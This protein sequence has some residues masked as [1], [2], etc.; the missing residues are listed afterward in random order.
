M[1]L[2]FWQ[3]TPGTDWPHNPFFKGDA[4]VWL[5]YALALERGRPFEL[6]LPL[7]PPGAA[8]LM[9]LLWD[10][11]RETI[12]WLRA[13]WALQGALVPPLL[14]VAVRQAF[15]PLVAWLASASAVA[16]TGL[17]LLSSALGNE[18][19][20][21]VLVLVTLALFE[22]LRARPSGVRLGLWSLVHGTACLFRVEHA[23]FYALCLGLLL[24]S[25]ARAPRGGRGGS[26]VSAG[27]AALALSAASFAVP[28]LPWHL[29]AWRAVRLFNTVPPPPEGEA[30]FQRLEEGLGEVT[31]DAGASA[32][33]QQVPA[34]AR[35]S[36]GAFVA[37]TVVHRGSRR[38]EASDFG[39]LEEAFGY[40]P[41]P[42]ARFP[43]VAGY[44]PL[45]FALA[46]AAG[47]R[48]GFDR[49]RLHEPPPLAGGAGRYPPTLVQGLPPQDLVLTYPPHLR[50]YNEGYR[51]GLGWI[52]GNPAAFASLVALKLQIFWDGAALGFTGYNLP[53]GLS[54]VRRAVD[55]V[56]PEAGAAALAW[57][58]LVLVAAVAG[59][60]AAVGRPGLHPWLLFLLSKVLVTVAFFGYARQGALV[61]PVVLLLVALAAERWLVCGRLAKVAK[62]PHL[63]GIVVLAA[64]LV[65]EQARWSARPQV[66]IDGQAVTPRADPVPVDVHRDH[67]VDVRSGPAMPPP[68]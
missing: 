64:A 20:Y 7:R 52:A 56:V 25:W 45:N 49:S 19:P 16:S 54:G 35:R 36:A 22:P 42:L 50:L 5:E 47:A 21:L 2:L 30:A 53:L 12:D 3:A 62:A 13:A 8:Y 41:R 46:N 39:V 27:V 10:G 61:A 34:F 59:L 9:A 58:A 43:F 67:R 29:H 28:L 4:V 60:I 32:R 40:M 1:R 23:L 31:W 37:A 48:G 24:V 11:R 15:S 26:R 65:V 33:R 68:R 57:R 66:L 51:I 63:L 18:T 6:D 55:L 38:V 14:F 44:G 17:V